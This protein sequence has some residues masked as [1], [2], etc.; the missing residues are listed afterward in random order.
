MRN[1]VSPGKIY[2]RV[3]AAMSFRYRRDRGALVALRP[4]LIAIVRGCL[5]NPR[6]KRSRCRPKIRPNHRIPPGTVWPVRGALAPRILG[7]RYVRPVGRGCTRPHRHV[8]EHMGSSLGSRHFGGNSEGRSIRPRKLPNGI[9]REIGMAQVRA[10][11]SIDNVAV[12]APRRAE[13]GV[14]MRSAARAP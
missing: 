3:L 1:K 5:D 9:A 7:A 14:H 11:L 13:N 4:A 2:R 6:P 8:R 12:D 10:H